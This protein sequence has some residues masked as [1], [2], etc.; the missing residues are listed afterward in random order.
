MKIYSNEYFLPT[1]LLKNN[2]KDKIFNKMGAKE[3]QLMMGSFYFLL[4]WAI[5]TALLAPYVYSTTQKQ[6]Y[7]IPNLR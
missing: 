6:M 3:D 1:S 4:A 5:F 7:K 2:I